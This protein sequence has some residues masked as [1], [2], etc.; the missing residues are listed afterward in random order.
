MCCDTCWTDGTLCSRCWLPV[1]LGGLS[2]VGGGAGG[3][4]VALHLTSPLR[5]AEGQCPAH[6][7]VALPLR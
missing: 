7:C 5:V 6:R 1:S 4:L 2:G 3:G